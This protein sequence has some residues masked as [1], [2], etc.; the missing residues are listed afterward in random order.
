MAIEDLWYKNAIIYCVPVAKYMDSDGDGIG[1]LEGLSRRLD[2][3]AGLGVT[4]VW[5]LPINKIRRGCGPPATRKRADDRSR[6][7]DSYLPGSEP[8]IV[9][10]ETS[11]SRSA[12]MIVPGIAPM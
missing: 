9:T 12:R 6:L 10:C 8:S 5:L 3:L 2:Y 7:I 11:A 1:D 4:C